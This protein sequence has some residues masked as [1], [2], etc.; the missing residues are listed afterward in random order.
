MINLLLPRAEAVGWGIVAGIAVAA[1][2][3]D[4]VGR[5]EEK[6]C[7]EYEKLQRI[8]AVNEKACD[9]G[10]CPRNLDSDISDAVEFDR[11]LLEISTGYK[12]VATVRSLRSCI[13]KLTS[14]RSQL[15]VPVM[16]YLNRKKAL[17]TS[18]SGGAR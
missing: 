8:C 10:A 3:M 9:K 12:C 11:P 2:A 7:K 6:H 1:V 4:I 16:E 17:E 5:V 18:Q 15:S 14:T 13:L